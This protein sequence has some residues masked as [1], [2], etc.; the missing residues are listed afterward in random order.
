MRPVPVFILGLQRSGTT[1]IG[2]LLAAHPQVA[3][4][5]DERHR[6]IHESV[7]FSHFAKAWDW[8]CP[9]QRE[10]AISAFLQSDYGRL[11]SLKDSEV[12]GLHRCETPALAFRHGMDCFAMRRASLAWI[13]KS[14]HHMQVAAEIA[15]DMPDAKFVTIGRDSV[16]LVS[17]RLHAYGRQRKAGRKRLFSILRGTVSNAYHRKLLSR[18][19]DIFPGRVTQLDYGAFQ[20][21]GDEAVAGLLTELGLTLYP[22]LQ[23]EFA[24]N[25]SFADTGERSSVLST[26]EI[27]L[28][29]KLDAVISRVPFSI[30]DSLR[31]LTVRRHVVFPNWVWTPDVERTGPNIP[32]TSELGL[33]C[34]D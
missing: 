2:N 24:P 25:S 30:L 10:A 6:G 4:V 22:G 32:R 15:T 13:E 3:A 14:P 17:S 19:A 28:V 9:D 26:F 5:V 29:S 27:S 16:S 34:R 7:F 8:S 31:N 11:L 23:S 18:F 12:A 1:W 20:S 21:G 33:P